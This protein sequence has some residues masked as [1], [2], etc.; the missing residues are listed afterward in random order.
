MRTTFGMLSL[1][2]VLGLTGVSFA[3]GDCCAVGN[4]DKAATTQPSQA[5]GEKDKQCTGKEGCDHCKA[6]TDAEKDK[7]KA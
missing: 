1:L 4:K 6:K 3:G 7:A 2:A 5:Q